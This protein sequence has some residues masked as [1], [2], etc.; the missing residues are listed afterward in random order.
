MYLNTHTPL[1]HRSQSGL[2]M[3]LSR[4]SVGILSGN[5][6]LC[7]LSGNTWSQLSQL[8][9]PLWT[10]SDIKSGISVRELISTIKKKKTQ[11]EN[12]WSDILLKNL[13]KRGK[14]H[15]QYPAPAPLIYAPTDN[16]QLFVSFQDCHITNYSRD[17]Q[18][19][20]IQNNR[21]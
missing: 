14:S 17:I 6:L 7:N 3:L 18:Y 11:A 10:N 15:H 1:T 2:T 13:S 8:T 21:F 16:G 4:Q 19:L 12:E 9:E 5:L 20:A